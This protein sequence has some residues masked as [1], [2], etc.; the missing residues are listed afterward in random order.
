M[1]STQ[2][3]LLICAEAADGGELLAWATI[4]IIF[5]SLFLRG[6]SFLT[7]PY[8]GSLKCISRFSEESYD[9]DDYLGKPQT[10]DQVTRIRFKRFFPT[11]HLYKYII[12]LLYNAFQFVKKL[13]YLLRDSN[14][15]DQPT[16]ECTQCYSN[17]SLH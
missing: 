3:M 4:D 8:L 11:L 14:L 7:L 16:N 12:Q 17:K 13:I 9:S 2:V 15:P 5:S 10:G 6:S 1:N